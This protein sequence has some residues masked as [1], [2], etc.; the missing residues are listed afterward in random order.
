M[1]Q[2]HQFFVPRGSFKGPV[3][4]PTSEPLLDRLLMW[5]TFGSLMALHMLYFKQGPADISPF[6]VLAIL[7]GHEAMNPSATYIAHADPEMADTMH[8]WLSI[9]HEDPMPTNPLDPLSSFL[10]HYIDMQVVFYF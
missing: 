2:M 8:P 7:G 5:R 6:L 9:T 1:I 10:M 4:L 3:F